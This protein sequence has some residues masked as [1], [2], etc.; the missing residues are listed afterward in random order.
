MVEHDVA[1]L[2]NLPARVGKLSEPVIR[3]HAR[4]LRVKQETVLPVIRP[5]ANRHAEQVIV[6]VPVRYGQHARLFQVANPIQNQ[7]VPALNR[8]PVVGELNQN[9]AKRSCRRRIPCR[10]AAAAR[11]QF[12]VVKPAQAMAVRVVVVK[13]EDVLDFVG[14]VREVIPE[15]ARNH[16]ALRPPARR[17]QQRNLT[18]ARPH[19]SLAPDGFRFHRH[20]VRAQRLAVNIRADVAVKMLAVVPIRMTRRGRGSH[21]L[22]VGKC[23]VRFAE[24][25]RIA[26]Q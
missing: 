12:D 16:R 15:L 13:R 7:R 14:V 3:I 9:L 5:R 24:I 4:E 25:Q 6:S 26:R 20:P 21:L 23:E 22:S 11:L 8:R 2:N 17:V 1:R 10:H 18:A 19:Q